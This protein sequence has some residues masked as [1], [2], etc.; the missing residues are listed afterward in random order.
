MWTA[1]IR[2]SNS[3]DSLK[4][5]YICQNLLMPR[6]PWYIDWFNSPFYYQLCFERN[7]N[8]AEKFLYKLIHYLEPSTGCRMLDVACGQGLFSRVLASMDFEVT[9]TDISEYAITGAKQFEK[10]N[11]QFY[12]HDIRR[13]FWI[14]YFDYVFNFFTGFGYFRTRREHED[15]IRT[16]CNS[17]KSNGVLV[18]DYLNVHYVEN[19]LV[20]EEEKEINVTTY[21]IR[22]WQDDTHFYKNIRIQYSTLPGPIEFTEEVSKLMLGDF[23]DM[24]SYQGMQ[25][26]SVFGDYELNPYDIEKTPRMIIVAKK[27]KV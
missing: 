1:K 17:L 15:A 13:P 24:L 9:G 5:Y 27:I 7:K 26:I 23:T 6:I 19:H 16:I 22:R 2:F 11:L 20:A 18:M 4:H 10:E 21:H 14:N 8:E 12:L 3:I 25:I